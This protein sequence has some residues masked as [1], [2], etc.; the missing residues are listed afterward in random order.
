MF[1]ADFVL[2]A[3]AAVV[4]LFVLVTWARVLTLLRTDAEERRALDEWWATRRQRDTS[5]LVD[6]LPVDESEDSGPKRAA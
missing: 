4:T 1:D 2:F 5:S 6:D 3:F